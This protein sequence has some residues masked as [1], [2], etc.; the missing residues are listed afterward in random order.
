MPPTF[1]LT[2]VGGV[3]LNNLISVPTTDAY[4]ILS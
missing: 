4:T 2:V 3:L 1:V